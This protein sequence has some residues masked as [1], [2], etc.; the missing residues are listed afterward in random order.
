MLDSVHLTARQWFIEP[1]MEIP[2]IL[3]NLERCRGAFPSSAVAEAIARREAITSELL[4]ILERLATNPEPFITDDGNFS[5]LFAIFLLAKFRET[6]AQQLVVR[7][8]STPGE[9]VLELLGDVATENLGSILASVSG[10]DLLPMKCLIENEQANE[11]VRS[12]AMKAMVILVATGQRARDEVMEYFRSLFR[13]LERRPTYV[14]TGLANHCTDLYPEEVQDE[15]RQAYADGLIDRRAIH[16]HDVGVTMDLG[17]EQALENL[18]RKRFHLVE[19]L[20]KEM[21]WMAGFE[22]LRAHSVGAVSDR[23]ESSEFE[24]EEPHRRSAPKVG[25]NEACPCGSG[26]KFKKCCGR[27]GGEYHDGSPYPLV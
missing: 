26:K 3:Q 1:V 9:S 25:R 24:V 8:V 23:E 19:D 15:I 20:E 21:G 4:R 7:I 27:D 17:K 13:R 10:C 22:P 2:E 18:R 12:A 11:Y 5:H 14:W 6:R 16:P